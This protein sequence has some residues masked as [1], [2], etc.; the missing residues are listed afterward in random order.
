MAFIEVVEFC[1]GFS[2]M[3]Y[4]YNVCEFIYVG[5]I[6]RRDNHVYFSDVSSRNFKIWWSSIVFLKL[7]FVLELGWDYWVL[8]EI[9]SILAVEYFVHAFDI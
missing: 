1:C 9:E 8:E 5:F 4:T 6:H 2:P 7:C 3:F